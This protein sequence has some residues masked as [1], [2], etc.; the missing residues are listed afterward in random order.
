MKYQPA[1]FRPAHW[2]ELIKPVGY[3]LLLT[4]GLAFFPIPFWAAPLVGLVVGG[5]AF[6]RERYRWVHDTPQCVEVTSLGLTVTEK[7]S[8]PQSVQWAGVSKVASD[9]KF[10]GWRIETADRVLRFGVAGLSREGMF[11]IET[12]IRENWR[13]Y[14]FEVPEA[15]AGDEGTTETQAR[16]GASR[17]GSPIEPP[18]NSRAAKGPPSRS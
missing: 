7:L 1:L 13:R 9:D 5:G 6:L 14:R 16:L 10:G 4:T 18:D 8:A 2:S 3:L 15:E 11:A 12:A 17:S